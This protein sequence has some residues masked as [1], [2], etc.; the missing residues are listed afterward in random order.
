M[1]QAVVLENDQKER[2]ARAIVA[3]KGKVCPDHVAHRYVERGCV[4]KE[5][6]AKAVAELG[7]KAAEADLIVRVYELLGGLVLPEG[8]TALE[9][10]L[11]KQHKEMMKRVRKEKEEQIAVAKEKQK[12]RTVLLRKGNKDSVVEDDEDIDDAEEG[13]SPVK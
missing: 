9:V 8:T 10:I 12:G 3:S 2:R 7:Q 1:P 5:V 6:Y 11:E 4:E 13:F